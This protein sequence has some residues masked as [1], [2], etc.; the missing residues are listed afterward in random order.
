MN[1]DQLTPDAG[2]KTRAFEVVDTSLTLQ[3]LGPKDWDQP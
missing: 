2:K 1:T 3:D